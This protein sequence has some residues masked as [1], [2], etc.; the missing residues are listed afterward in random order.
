M[1]EEEA[2]GKLGWVTWHLLDQAFQVSKNSKA[3]L[4]RALFVEWH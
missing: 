2:G 3:F 1:T 4:V